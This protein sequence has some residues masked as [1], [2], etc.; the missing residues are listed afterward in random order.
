VN[1]T[2]AAG[3]GVRPLTGADLRDVPP[4]WDYDPS[5]WSQRLPIVGL[6]AVGFGIALYLSLYQWGVLDRVFDPF[7]GKLWFGGGSETI[8]RESAISRQSLRHLG[9][10]DAF[11]GALAY[12][13]DAVTGLVGGTGRW[14]TRPWLVIAF[15]VLVGPLGLVSVL[16]VIAQPLLSGAW[17]SLC[18]VSAAISVV[19][20]GPALDEVLATLQHLARVRRAGRPLWPAFVGGAAAAS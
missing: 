20:I 3:V 10:P 18:L 4:G 6:A 9:M 16:L 1:G 14:R 19:L 17:C 7:F 11:L 12:L 15:G 5:A 2:E 8:L 13:A